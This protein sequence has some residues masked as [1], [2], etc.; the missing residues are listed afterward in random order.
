MKILKSIAVAFSMY[1]RIPMPRFNW[2]SEDMKY[3]LIFFPFVGMII[4]AVLYLWHK[5][6]YVLPINAIPFATISIV[7]PILITGGFHVDGYMDTCDALASWGDRKKKLEILKDSHIGAFSVI[8]LITLGIILFTAVYLMDD[9]AFLTWC[10]SFAIVRA[11]SGICVVRS[12]KAKDDGILSTSARTA[13][14]NI[15]VACLAVEFIICTLTAGWIFQWYCTYS[16]LALAVVLVYYIYVAYT[17]FG[18][19]TGDLAGWFV[20]KAEVFMAIALAICSMVNNPAI[21]G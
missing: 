8:N 10:F 3:H 17:K 19:I 9:K 7:I 16:F 14:N 2:D 15:V 21:L 4:G 11:V 5:L 1:S 18:G 13:S 12:K 20:C 6:Y